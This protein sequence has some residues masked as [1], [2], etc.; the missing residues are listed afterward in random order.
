M[1][2]GSL[3]TCKLVSTGLVSVIKFVNYDKTRGLFWL[4]VE[5]GIIEIIK[6]VDL[7]RRVGS[8]ACP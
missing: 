3:C 2:R 6:Y 4:L 7:A 5:M 8:R 1:Y